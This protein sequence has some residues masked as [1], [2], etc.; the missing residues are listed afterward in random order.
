MK[1]VILQPSYV[2]WRGYFDQI[3]RADVFVFYDCVQYDRRGW[4][5]RNKIKTPNGLQWLTIPVKS[6]DV[7]T[8]GTPISQISIDWTQTWNVRHREMI[9]RAYRRAPHYH[10]F[11]DLLDDFY[12]RKEIKLADFTIELTISLAHRLGLDNTQFIRS[13]QLPAIGQKSERLLSILQHLGATHYISGP[14]AREYID[15]VL[16]ERAGI[17]LEFMEYD[18][19]EYPQLYPPYEPAVSILDLLF[20]AGSNA[21]RYVIPSLQGQDERCS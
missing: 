13:S 19:P 6:K 3:A 10:E 17:S 21:W 16:F 7:Q 9:H 15:D 5:N 4:R 14:S 12:S 2:P 18:Y 11:V 8:I 20:M 1:C